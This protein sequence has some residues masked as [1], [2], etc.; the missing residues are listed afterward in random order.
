[1]CAV[2]KFSL[3]SILKCSSCAINSGHLV[4]RSI[5]KMVLVGLSFDVFFLFGDRSIGYSCTN[6]YPELVGDVGV[7]VRMLLYRGNASPL[8]LDDIAVH[9]R[10]DHIVPYIQDKHPLMHTSLHASPL[11]ESQASCVKTLW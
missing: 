6:R 4:R 5:C 3:S 9:D 11:V 2:T 10:C 7:R 1:M 8:C